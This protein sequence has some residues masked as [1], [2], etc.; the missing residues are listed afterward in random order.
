MQQDSIIWA[1]LN[2][3]FC[4]HKVKTKTQNFCRNEFNVTGKCSRSS[5]PLANSNYATVREEEGKV[6]LYVKTIERAAFPAKLW[7]KIKLSENNEKAT[8]QIEHHLMYW[9]R[10]IKTRCKHRMAKIVQYLTRMRRLAL[11]RTKKIM[12][13]PRKIER[14]ERRREVKALLAAKLDNAI[15]KELLERLKKGT[16]NELYNFSEKTFDTAL[17]G[18]EE[19]SEYESE[20]EDNVEMEEEEEEIEIGKEPIQYVAADQF[21]DSDEE[22]QLEEY[23]AG[24]GENSSDGSSSED[25]A[26]KR[27]KKILGKKG[28]LKKARIEIEYETETASTSKQP[29][30]KVKH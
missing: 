4:S 7:E 25:E 26:D 6:F 12:T 8:A 3:T 9:P 14:R 10:S 28:I 21:A 15:E 22:D 2:D 19:E 20:R 11:R 18:E 17:N 27:K 29:A 23:L 1:V 30:V 13:M 24:G 16:Y 5:C